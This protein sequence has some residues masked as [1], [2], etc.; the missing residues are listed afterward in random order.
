MKKDKILIMRVSEDDLRVLGDCIARVNLL[1]S[2]LKNNKS[3]T[4]MIALRK[5]IGK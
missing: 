3:V 1:D 4:I 5:F 2:S